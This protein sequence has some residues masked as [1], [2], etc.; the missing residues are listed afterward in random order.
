[1]CVEQILK[2]KINKVCDI[3]MKIV[4]EITFMS[5]Y[6]SHA[7]NC[8]VDSLSIYLCDFSE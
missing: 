4:A 8:S 7:L 6:I 1:M 2:Q 5:D 3:C